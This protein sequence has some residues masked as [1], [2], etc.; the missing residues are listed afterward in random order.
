MRLVCMM[1]VRQVRRNALRL[2]LCLPTPSLPITT[3]EDGKRRESCRF[4]YLHIILNEPWFLR[5]SLSC[6]RSSTRLSSVHRVEMF[7]S[8]Y[9]LL[10]AAR[11]LAQ[12]VT[13]RPLTTE[14]CVHSS[15]SPC[16]ICVGHS[17]TVQPLIHSHFIH[18]RS[19]LLTIDSVVK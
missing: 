1:D 13:R 16:G 2:V 7:R 9:T 5:T 19:M 12:A 18:R 17:L 6:T 8:I 4:C 14:A 15:A 3:L 11:T 10:T